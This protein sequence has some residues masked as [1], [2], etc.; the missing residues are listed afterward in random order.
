M[1]FLLF[2]S[3]DVVK[4]FY[5]SNSIPDNMEFFWVYNP[6]WDMEWSVEDTRSPKELVKKQ[7]ILTEV[8]EYDQLLSIVQDIKPDIGLVVGSKWIFKEDFLS[9]FKIR[10]FNYHPANLPYYRGAGVFSWQILNG[11]TETYVTIHEMV[12]DVDAGGIALQKKRFVGN[13]VY[14]KDFIRIANDLAVETISTFISEISKGNLFQQ[15][16]PQ[17]I[18]SSTYFPS[19]RSANNGAINWNWDGYDIELFI[20]AF[21]YPYSG[22]FTYFGTEKK[23]VRLFDSE[24]RKGKTYHPFTFGLVLAKTNESIKVAV[25]GGELII[26]LPKILS[27]TNE[28]FSTVRIGGR[29]WTPADQLDE[30]LSYRALNK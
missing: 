8:K 30:A 14:P 23:K 11:E 6:D 19:L 21:S 16:T 27:D 10:V 3:G 18:D 24:F 28:V 12:K 17:N 5:L 26:E 20:R 9:N 7:N 13:K 15:L 2:G 25:K 4:K 22:A 1:K 29:F